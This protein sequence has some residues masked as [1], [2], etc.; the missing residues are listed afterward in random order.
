MNKAFL[1]IILTLGLMAQ[2]QEIFL[3]KCPSQTV[4]ENF[5]LS[6][7]LGKWYENRSYFA[8]FQIGGRC[9]TAI[10]TDAGNG[11]VKVENTQINFLGKTSGVVGQAKLANPE[12][13][14][15]KLSVSFSS[16]TPYEN[17]ANEVTDSNYWVLDTDYTS[18][19]VV[20]S[21]RN[22]LI[23]NTQFLWI[24]TRERNPPADVI[25]KA[26]AVIARRGLDA[27]RLSIT[28]QTDCKN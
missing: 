3:K 26:L 19:A 11:L 28:E 23:F 16:E 15:G 9:T 5:D 2:A 13:T 12:S 24:L 22:A 7:Y 14:E 18:Y 10:Y 27:T 4:V 1:F 20:W 25:D 8:I 17:M 21:C 6:R